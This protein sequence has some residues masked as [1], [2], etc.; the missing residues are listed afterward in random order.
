MS[1]RRTGNL[2]DVPPT[3]AGVHRPH[4]EGG[5]EICVLAEHRQSSIYLLVV[6]SSEESPIYL[7]L[8]AFNRNSRHFYHQLH[9]A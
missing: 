8:T 6:D 1:I 9:L 2:E 7:E 5:P 3:Q 4:N